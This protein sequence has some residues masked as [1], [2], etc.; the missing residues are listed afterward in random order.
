MDIIL[1]KLV[2]KFRMFIIGNRR[3]WKFRMEKTFA[4]VNVKFVDDSIIL[5]KHDR[6]IKICNKVLLILKKNMQ[7]GKENCEA[8]GV[9]I[10]RENISNSN[11]IVEYVTEPM[12]GDRRS[13]NRYYREDKGHIEFYKKIYDKNGGV[14]A[15]VGEWHTHPEAIPQ[16]S[17]LDLKNW[18]TI[19]KEAGK[20][21]IHLHIIVGYDAI[22][23]WEFS[24]YDKKVEEL[25]TVF[26]SEVILD[27]QD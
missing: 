15:Y 12:K 2:L 10:G 7:S 1:K 19:G 20:G 27:E 16:Y 3:N 24:F 18:K 9:L 23:I 21:N 26:W 22:R 25:A 4:K 14:Y 8:G 13:R 5:E 11:L 6:H 17:Y